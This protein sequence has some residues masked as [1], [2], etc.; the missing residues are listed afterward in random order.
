ML[1]LPSE[2]E[3]GQVRGEVCKDKRNL[4]QRQGVCVPSWF[5]SVRVMQKVVGSPNLLKSM[6][7]SESVI[8]KFVLVLVWQSS[9]TCSA[10]QNRVCRACC[11]AVK[12]G[13]IGTVPQTIRIGARTDRVLARQIVS[14]GGDI[15]ESVWHWLAK[16]SRLCC[17][18]R[19]TLLMQCSMDLRTIQL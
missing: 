14:A 8:I 19:W 15:H 18:F 7:E 5:G 16:Q 3:H 9:C 17:S 1:P 4:C 2:E 10:L 13:R 11:L 12:D 6:V